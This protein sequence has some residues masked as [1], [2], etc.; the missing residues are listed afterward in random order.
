[1]ISQEDM[2]TNLANKN[3]PKEIRSGTAGSPGGGPMA[4]AGGPLGVP[5]PPGGAGVEPA[6]SGNVAGCE[7]GAR[8]PTGHARAGDP[9]VGG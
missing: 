1:V 9:Q 6:G 2:T 8:D 5:D 4:A 3:A 7:V